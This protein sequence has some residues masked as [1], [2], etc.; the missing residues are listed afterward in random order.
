MDKLRV[1]LIFEDLF[2]VEPGTFQPA[3]VLREEDIDCEYY[4]R[5]LRPGEQFMK[6]LDGTFAS[7]L[8]KR[9][10]EPD[11]ADFFDCEKDEKAEVVIDV[12]KRA[13]AA[14]L[15]RT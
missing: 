14:G 8:T 10:S 1:P 7:P 12:S 13:S 2:A 3:A 11:V 6:L 9:A 15:I 5:A 4:E